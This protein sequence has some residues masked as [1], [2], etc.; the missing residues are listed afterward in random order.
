[1]G[2]FKLLLAGWVLLAGSSPDTFGLPPFTTPE[3]EWKFDK[4]KVDGPGVICARSKEEWAAAWTRYVPGEDTLPDVDFERVMVVG[5]VGGKADQP[6]G[7]YRIELDDAAAPA[8][9]MVRCS[10]A[11]A[12]SFKPEKTTITGSKLHL[13]ATARSALPVRFVMDSMVDGHVFY[14]NGGVDETP[15]GN[16]PGLPLPPKHEGILFREEVEKRVRASLKDEEIAELKKELEHLVHGLRYPQLWSVVSVRWGKT[17]WAV[18]Y[19]RMKFEVDAVSGE[20]R[21]L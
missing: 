3:Q 20:V 12:D 8:A 6:R 13:V 7:I 17:A 9:L 21:R 1:M 19:D 16:V 10:H 15:L 14:M 2:H 18:T 4:T 11:S 5:I